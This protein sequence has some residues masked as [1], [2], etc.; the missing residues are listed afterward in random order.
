[1]RSALDQLE[2]AVYKVLDREV[3][4]RGI[5][6]R[7][8]HHARR[9]YAMRRQRD[10]LVKDMFGEPAWDMLLEL[11]IAEAEGRPTPVKNL[12]LA[13][14]ASVSTALRRLDCLVEAGL[15]GKVDD[16]TD[17]RR[18]LIQLTDRGMGVMTMLL[19][20][21]VFERLPAEGGHRQSHHVSQK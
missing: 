9:Q 8:V 5:S 21:E 12:C 15:V 7:L 14:C 10:V 16:A 17:A 18:S 13:A 11:F 3:G 1:M 20:Y 4:P 6:L 2:S 19:Q